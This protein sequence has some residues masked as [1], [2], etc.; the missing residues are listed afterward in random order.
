MPEVSGDAHVL[1]EET[2]TKS[3]IYIP[4]DDIST[5]LGSLSCA[6]TSTFTDIG[7]TPYSMCDA[8]IA[9]TGFLPLS[10]PDETSEIGLEPYL[11]LFD[12]TKIGSVHPNI[13][14]PYHINSH[15][16]DFNFSQTDHPETFTGVISNDR[17]E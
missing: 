10:W 14:I 4:A 7:S 11:N 13:G 6:S 3:P 5:P 2:F 12:E 9:D 16:V 15:S 8:S 17:S 1:S